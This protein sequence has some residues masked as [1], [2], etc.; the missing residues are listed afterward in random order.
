VPAIRLQSTVPAVI[1]AAALAVCAAAP[2]RAELGDST[3]RRGDSG[4]S[5]AELQ[6]ALTRLGLRTAADGEFGAATAKSVRRWERRSERRIDGVVSRPD[7]RVMLRQLARRP[8]TPPPAPAPG[9]PAGDAESTDGRPV[10][11]GST[12]PATLV[13]TA[14]SAA[15]ERIDVVDD[16]GAAV[17]SLTDTPAAAGELRAVR[18]DGRIAGRDAP[19]GT[20]RFRLS[21]TAAVASSSSLRPFPLLSEIFPIRGRHQYGTSINRF[22]AGR[23]GRSH[24]G[25]DVFAPCGSAIKAVQGGRVVYAGYQSAA[26]NYIVIRGRSSGRD[27]V[28]MHMRSPARYDTGAKVPT[29][30]LIGRV[31]E[32]G[33]AVGCHVH[34]ELWT[35]PGWYDGGR[36]IDPLPSLR[37]W[38]QKT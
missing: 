15:P 18:W 23:G 21:G 12:M 36:A 20:Y 37:A 7:G 34:F 1:L 24:R 5:V 4:A 10:F 29:A 27:Y 31:G 28:Y 32:T 33:N 22:G 6:R 13:Y 30:A 3:L 2:A 35:K 9:T 14:R 17:V 26:G 16:A 38:D 11:L 19:L 25:Q 8:A